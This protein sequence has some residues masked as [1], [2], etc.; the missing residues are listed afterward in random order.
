M[1]N[2]KQI[3]DYYFIL[4]VT[5]EASASEID[6]AYNHY[7]VMWHPDK[8]KQD[9]QEAQKKFKDICE[10]YDILSDKN[11]KANYD[12]LVKN[13]FSI[14]EAEKTFEKFYSL[15]GIVNEQ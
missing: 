6:E 11:K 4:G 13:E 3:K 5:Q 7:A 14:E 1:S 9:R 12:E 10:A 8:H 2:T 15:N